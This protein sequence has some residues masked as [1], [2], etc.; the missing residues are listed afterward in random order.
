M[1]ARPATDTDASTS[2]VSSSVRHDADARFSARSPVPGPDV[3]AVSSAS[4]SPFM[5]FL[6]V[7]VISPRTLPPSRFLSVHPGSRYGYADFRS[8][9]MPPL[10]VA[11]PGPI[12]T[13]AVDH[14][15]R[16]HCRR[17][18]RPRSFGHAVSIRRMSYTLTHRTLI[19]PSA[20]GWTVE[21]RWL[22]MQR[23]DPIAD[24][25]ACKNSMYVNAQQS[26][27]Y[28]RR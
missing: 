2:M 16:D 22:P 11:E 6:T 5:P 25:S 23:N 28:H 8:M 3:Y 7:V 15:P 18:G 10:P 13:A 12:Q 9:Y 4:V 20:P 21:W 17:G 27:H 19:K 24:H 14:D 1:H 26:M